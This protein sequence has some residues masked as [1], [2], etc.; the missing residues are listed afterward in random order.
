[1]TDMR[2]HRPSELEPYLAHLQA[3]PFV[4]N[5][6]V[7]LA[8]TR[9]GHILPDALLR[10]RTPSGEHALHMELKRTH[11]TRPLVNGLLNQM[12]AKKVAGWI[13]FAP[14]I[15]AEIGGYLRENKANYVDAAGNCFVTFRT[16][17]IALVEGRRPPKRTLQDRGIRGP[18]YQILF[19]ILARP[20][21]LDVPVRTLAEAAGAGKS[22]T[23]Q[24]LKRLEAEGLVGADR[25][26]RRLLQPQRLMDRW[27]TGYATTVR[28]RLVMGRFRTNDPDTE[29]LEA[30][31][32]SVLGETVRWAW[33]GGAAAM[34]LTGYYRGPDT[35]LHL[36]HPLPDLGKRLRGIPDEDGPVIILGAPGPVAFAGV[37]PR[38]VHPLLIFTELLA[39]GDERALDAAEEIRRRHLIGAAR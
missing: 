25:T 15:G 23:A 18:G 22:A 12:R 16:Q 10:L 32:A 6:R 21:L 14:Y 35:L 7:D 26:G 34:R 29:T 1:M 39:A 37:Q 8:D 4:R 28:P 11:V 2:P 20:E 30:R 3:L 38:T 24:M 13:L 9:A 19:A 31:I 5:V 33:G 17:Y 27:L 36:E